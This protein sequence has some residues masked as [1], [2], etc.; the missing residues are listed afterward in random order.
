MT[1]ANP[2]PR[3]HLTILLR[4]PTTNIPKEGLSL[5]T[6]V[7]ALMNFSSAGHFLSLCR[8]QAMI[9]MQAVL[10][11]GTTEL[12]SSLFGFSP[13]WQWWQCQCCRQA[14]LQA[15]APKQLSSPP[16]PPPR[17]TAPTLWNNEVRS[18]PTFGPDFLTL[19]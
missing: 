16:S 2:H 6:T 10:E 9:E 19:S 12:S 7:T 3:S 5:P 11:A 17:S 1:R 15:K 8:L 18:K 4:W 13:L 14:V